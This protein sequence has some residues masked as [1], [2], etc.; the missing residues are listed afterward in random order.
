MIAR[1]AAELNSA[2]DPADDLSAYRYEPERY[3][4]E[5]LGWTPWRGTPEAPGQADV[6]DAYVEALRTQA[7]RPGA[8]V[9]NW[10]R[11]EAGHT[12]G[13][14]TLLAGV[15]SHFFD[16]WGPSITYCFAPGYE[17]INDLLFKE[18]RTQRAGQRLPGR[19]L[20]TPEIKHRGDWFVKG[21]ATNNAHGQGTERIQ[22][23]HGPRLL[24][25]VDEAEGVPDFV[26]DAIDSMASGGLAIILLAANPRTRT[27][28]FH[29]L[30]ASPRCRSFRIS[31]LFHPNVT[32]GRDLIPGAVNR[33]WIDSKLDPGPSQLAEVTKAYDADALTFSVP[34]RPGLIYRPRPEFLWRVMGIAPS[35]NTT[36]TLIP[37][38]RYEAAKAR[39]PVPRNPHQARA[40]VDV[41]RY[42]QD[43]GTLYIRHAGRIWR[44]EAFWHQNTLEYIRVIKAAAQ[45]LAAEGVTSFH[46]RVDGGGGYGGGIVDLLGADEDLRRLFADF[47]VYEVHFGG[48]PTDEDAY[49]DVITELYADAGEALP[50]LRIEDPPD[51]L[52][53]D[54]CERR[55]RFVKLRGVD[56]KRLES[57]EEFRK[58]NDQK[59]SPDDGDGFVL[60]AAA[61]HLFGSD[62]VFL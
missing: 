54:L 59:S 45:R 35:G 27:S 25:V 17:Q 10:I 19:V 48:T 58:R 32:S 41:A 28:R 60:A 21:K 44:E 50:A 24:F 42:G 7:E 12:V 6:L 43:A 36:D 3:I 20:E 38:G 53:R 16:C 52:E 2:V 9:R 4:R 55:Y 34:W 1:L 56:V 8:P 57:K 61:D 46:V 47:Q 13:K 31:S 5:R 18:I 26:Y 40:G 62:G 14:T 23:Q 51:V 15:V 37:V 11:I 30:A 22:G 29:K 49:A 39:Q 33:S